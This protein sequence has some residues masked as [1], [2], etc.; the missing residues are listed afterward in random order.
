MGVVPYFLNL[1]SDVLMKII[2][3]HN[4]VKTYI[5]VAFMWGEVVAVWRQNEDAF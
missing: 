5:Y 2:C 3:V 4:Q 1:D